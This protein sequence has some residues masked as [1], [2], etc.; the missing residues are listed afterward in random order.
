MLSD[1]TTH[2]HLFP[3]L[4]ALLDDELGSEQ[5]RLQRQDP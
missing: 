1:H 2:G 4:E 5:G 3:G